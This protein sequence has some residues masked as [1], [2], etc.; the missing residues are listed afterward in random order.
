V[1]A[2]RQG[3]K[4]TSYVEGQ[5]VAIEFHWADGHCG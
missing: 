4:E 5:D 1:T 3:L 2:F